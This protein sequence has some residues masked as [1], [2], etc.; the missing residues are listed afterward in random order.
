M[1]ALGPRQNNP[2]SW[3]SRYSLLGQELLIWYT[4]N[5]AF[6]QDDKPR[7][8]AGSSGQEALPWVSGDPGSSSKSAANSLGDKEPAPALPP[9]WASVSLWY[10]GPMILRPNG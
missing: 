6:F 9:F 7:S 2:R 4:Y 8:L 5:P 3:V 10:Y 1:Q